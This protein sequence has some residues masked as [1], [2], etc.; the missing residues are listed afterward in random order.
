MRSVRE[1]PCL[2]RRLATRQALPARRQRPQSMVDEHQMCFSAS[3]PVPFLQVEVLF[4]KCNS[5][6]PTTAYSR[7]IAKSCRAS[8]MAQDSAKGALVCLLTDIEKHANTGQG[9]EQ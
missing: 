1:H 2:Q 9:D 8:W 7:R 3:P 6:V 4:P 5:D